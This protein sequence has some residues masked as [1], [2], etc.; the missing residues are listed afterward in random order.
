MWRL[1]KN[2]NI[3]RFDSREKG[4]QTSRVRH[5]P[6]TGES[7]RTRATR[8]LTCACSG[9]RRARVV[10]SDAH[11]WWRALGDGGGA[12]RQSR[13]RRHVRRYVSRSVAR[14]FG[15]GCDFFFDLPSRA[16]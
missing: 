14:F 16:V 10:A 11:V 4:P 2:E 5:R 13:R 8:P 15:G 3:N 9:E 6:R 12:E 7:A 1:L